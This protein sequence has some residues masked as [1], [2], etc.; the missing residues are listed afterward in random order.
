M[1]T[2]SPHITIIT[3]NVNALNSPI[4][5]HRATG[6]IKKQDPTICRLQET[7]L[8]SKDKHKIKGDINNN[9]IIVG[10][11]KTP[12]MD[13]SSRQKVNK[14]TGELNEKPDQM[15]LIDIYRESIPSKN[16]RIHIML[17]STWIILK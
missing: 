6:W 15:D 4:K 1:A 10:D 7:H 17:K 9:A 12:W 5:R 8:S 2:L 16:S 11:L 3:L 14:E 13:R